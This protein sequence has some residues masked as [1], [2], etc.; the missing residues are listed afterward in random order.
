MATHIRDVTSHLADTLQTDAI[1]RQLPLGLLV[2]EV[3]G[4][5]IVSANDRA[6]QLLAGSV[7]EPESI[8]E[9]SSHF[10]GFRTDGSQ[11]AADEWPLARAVVHG[12]TVEDEEIELRL[13]SGDRRVM[14]VSAAPI[15][16]ATGEVVHAVALFDDITEQRYS[17]RRH[18]FLMELSDRLGTLN[19]AVTMMETAVVATG[20][21]L[22]VTSVSFA[23]VDPRGRHALVP[24]EYRNGR[25]APPGKYYLEDF[26]APLAECMR[27]GTTVAVEDAGT[28]PVITGDLLEVWSIRSLI[29]VPVVRGGELMAIITVMHSAPRR[30]TRSDISL[31]EQVT[32]RT[33]HAVEVARVQ[34][35]LRQSRERLTLAL[36][37]G[38]AAVWEWDL[39]SGLIHW[40]EEGGGVL[41]MASGH[42]PLTFQRWLAL[43]HPDDR[44]A[45]REA[46]RRI[47][48]MR[49][50]E[51]EFEHGLA[52]PG[53]ARWLAMRGRIIADPAGVPHRVVGIAVNTTERKAA[54]LEREQLLQ[55]AREASE[56][57]S[58]FISVLSHEFRTPLAAIIGYADLLAGGVSGE[59]SPRQARQLDRICASA[60]HLTQMVDEILAFSRMEAGY[61]SV[62]PE[63]VDAAALAREATALVGPAAAAKGL[64]ITCELEDGSI[65]LITDSGKLR[66]VLL[67]LMGNAVKFTEKGGAT[68]AVR[69]K[70]DGVEFVVRDTG[71]G[72]A[73]EHLD[74]VFERYWQVQRRE[75]RG[76]TGAGL[77]LTVSRHLVGLLGGRLSVESELGKGSRFR[78]VLPHRYEP[79]AEA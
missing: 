22:G 33:W 53:E 41:G 63:Q 11:Y 73:P 19:D 13:A 62:V 68:M 67:N 21:Y 74:R 61:E 2:A 77:G 26:G 15:V 60:W 4:G 40:S 28:D 30:W 49:E 78:F 52:G 10:I 43:V 35:E 39:R 56:A 14:L 75:G 32:E 17:E 51:V 24:A 42:R 25:L 34:S 12:E 66:Q 57:K 65:D 48:V 37:A 59:L 6:E 72:I 7:P 16:G 27:R 36:G 79:P 8:D 9:Y 31:V 45:A 58:H 50:G 46:A 23:D 69:R 3:P 20:E 38:S 71:V 18:E 47:A 76:M 1:L 5:R 70:D 55:Q 64:G 29:A 54:E 44:T